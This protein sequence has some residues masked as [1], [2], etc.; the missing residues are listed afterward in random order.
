MKCSLSSILF[1]FAGIICSAQDEWLDPERNSFNRYPMHTN[2]FAYQDKNETE[3]PRSESGNYLSI[4]GVW[5]FN[6]VRDADMRPMDFYEVDFNDKG[7]DK[8]KV[9]A[10]WE[11][12]GYGSPIYVNVGYPWRSQFESRPP[13]FPI[14]NNHVGSY[15]REIV[16]PNNWKGK[17]IIAHFGAVSSN[18]Y[19]WVNGKY[20]GYSEDSKLEAE[21]DVTGY[22]KPGKNLFAVQVFRWCDGTYLEDQDFFRLSGISRDCYLYARSKE[23][24]E[25]IRV[26]PLLDEEYEDASLDISLVLKGN[27]DVRLELVDAGGTV[28]A[29]KNIRGKGRKSVSFDIKNPEKW[30]AETPY[31]YKLYASTDSEVIPV[32]VGFRSVEIKDNQLLVNGKAVLIKGANRHELDPDDGYVVSYERML[33]DIRRMKELNINAVRTCH[34]PDDNRWYDLCDKYGLYVVAETNIESHGMGYKEKTLAKEPSYA[35]AHLERNQRHV[36]RNFNNPSV[37]IWSLGNEAGFGSNF[38]ECYKWIKNEDPSRPVQYERA[39][40]NAFT[41]IFCPMY[42]GYSGNIKYLEN[43]GKPLIQC[44]YAHAMGNSMGG[45]KEYWDLIRSEPS[46]QG[47]FIWDFVDQSIHWRN[48]KGDD[49]YG[50]GGDFNAYDAHNYNFCDNGLISPDRRPNPHAG[51]VRYF[52][53]NI[54]SELKDR[55]TGE[56]S[57]FNEY[58]F[59]DLSAFYLEWELVENGEV[60]RRGVVSNIDAGPQQSQ[61]VR[62]NYNSAG[63]DNGNEWMLNLYYKLKEREYPLE[64][65]HIMAYQQL[66]VSVYGFGDVDVRNE[67]VTDTENSLPRIVDNDKYYLIVKGNGFQLDFHREDGFLHNYVVDGMNMLEEHSMFRPNFWRAPTD[68]DFGANLQKKWKIWKKPEIRLSKLSYHMDGG[69][70]VV[71]ADYDLPEVKASMTLSYTINNQGAI[72]VTQSLDASEELKQPNMFRFGMRMEMPSSY[73]I[74]EYY[75][76]GP[77]ENY[78]DRMNS[79]IIG[80]YRLHVADM[81]Y[82]YIR[83]QENGTRSD[84]RWWQ[85]LDRSGRGLKFYS[86]APFSASA[87]EYS[88]ESL[89]EGPKKIQ[90]HSS[91]LKKNGCVN[92]C[93]DKVQMGL[94]CVN[95]WG[96]IPLDEYCVPYKDYEFRLIIQ[97]VKHMFG[98]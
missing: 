44:E 27:C 7:W 49:I 8:L 75:G 59:R 54:W 81:F 68:N 1:L 79:T 21:F 85:V 56:I 93:I 12:N 74:V 46:Y 72:A 69:L 76:R 13:M 50:Y 28:V 63:L 24:I 51:E 36:R 89:D 53:Q 73:N 58:F 83:P 71:K 84:L 39:E 4:N 19:L 45:F 22:L 67:K 35:Q 3:K 14:E 66:P 15:R 23:R 92:I 57:V 80:R 97:P 48:S 98:H 90:R 52:Y 2:Y 61:N 82:P 91:E 77:A 37:I 55:N 95:S 64:S 30:T 38:E 65:G 17:D 78:I 10:N 87:L 31:L 40:K 16:I 20:V 42:Q 18:M 88:Q 9:P 70:A 32:N 6:W 25:D 43:A 96:A 33:Q 29:D 5:N 47:G 41:D 94:G 62:L 60:A 86:N 34:Y 11:L 26:T